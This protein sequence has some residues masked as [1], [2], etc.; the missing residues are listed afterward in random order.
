MITGFTPFEVPRAMEDAGPDLVVD[1][2]RN[3]T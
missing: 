2:D 3:R 1:T